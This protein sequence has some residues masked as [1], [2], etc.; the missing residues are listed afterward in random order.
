MKWSSPTTT[1]PLV[2]CGD[3]SGFDRRAALGAR[4]L[5]CEVWSVMSVVDGAA[6]VQL[7]VEVRAPSWRKNTLPEDRL[8]V[9]ASGVVSNETGEG[10]DIVNG[11]SKSRAHGTGSAAIRHRVGSGREGQGEDDD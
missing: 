3:T 1:A 2:G 9:A 11:G 5:T 6:R 8:H 7:S 4:V 10:I